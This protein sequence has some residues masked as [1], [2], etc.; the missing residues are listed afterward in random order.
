MLVLRVRGIISGC[1]GRD[2]VAMLISNAEEQEM[3]HPGAG[4][5]SVADQ[6][7]LEWMLENRPVLVRPQPA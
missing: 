3:S 4:A 1:E 2:F 7:V 6:W 5:Y